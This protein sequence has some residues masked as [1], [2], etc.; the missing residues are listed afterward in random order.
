[1]EILGHYLETKIVACWTIWIIR[2]EGFHSRS[3]Q[4]WMDFLLIELMQCHIY[5]FTCCT[6]SS[7]LHS[8]IVIPPNASGA[9]K[10]LGGELSL[11]RISTRYC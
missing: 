8:T 4:H 5:Y 6:S 9:T 10:L 7:R 2:E 11:V 1:M 3:L